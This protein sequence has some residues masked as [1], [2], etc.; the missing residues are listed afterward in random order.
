MFS[1]LIAWVAGAVA[2]AV[3]A[4]GALG[5]AAFAWSLWARHAEVASLLTG[6]VRDVGDDGYSVDVV[7]PDG[8]V[9]SLDAADAIYPI[10]SEVPVLVDGTWARLATEPYD[11][12]FWLAA[13]LTLAVT[14]GALGVVV[15]RAMRAVAVLGRPHHALEVLA[16]A[17]PRGNLLVWAADAGPEDDPL[18]S[19]GFAD[20]EDLSWPVWNHGDDGLADLASQDGAVGRRDPAILHAVPHDGALVPVEVRPPDEDPVLLVPWSRV[21]PGRARRSDRGSWDSESAELLIWLFDG[22]P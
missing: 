17:D 8:D 14:A 1:W 11:A 16:Y 7:L 4:V 13:A 5:Y 21:R 3:L 15:L 2:A 18:F 12:T 6:V 20:H 10:G 22:R 19:M 9:R